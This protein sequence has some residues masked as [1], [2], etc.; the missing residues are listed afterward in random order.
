MIHC[1]LWRSFSAFQREVSPP[2]PL[3]KKMILKIAIE[4]AD[5]NL[6][7]EIQKVLF[8]TSL[9]SCE[10][11]YGIMWNW[12]YIFLLFYCLMLNRIT[13]GCIIYLWICKYADKM[14][15]RPVI[16]CV[17][18]KCNYSLVLP[19]ICKWIKWNFKHK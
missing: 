1:N 11:L 8:R 15:T 19:T 9:D 16:V 3:P 13:F 7:Y 18:G 4:C 2:P 10:F 6:K 12:M 5:N 14:P 17:G